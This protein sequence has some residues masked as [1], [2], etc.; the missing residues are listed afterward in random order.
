MGQKK[1]IGELFENKLNN[2]KKNPNNNLWEKIN[3]SLDAEK[4]RNKKIFYYWLVGGGLTILFGLFLLINSEGLL[5]DTP[6]QENDTPLAQEPIFSSD[7]PAE[8][9][10]NKLNERT[11]VISEEER[12]Y[13]EIKSDEKLSKN[14]VSTKGLD[15][16]VK[17]KSSKEKTLNKNEHSKNKFKKED[18]GFTVSETYYYYNSRNNQQIKT[19]NIKEIDSLISEENK[20]KDTLNVK[21]L[22]N[23]E[24]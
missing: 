13:N 18:E 14:D 1:D 19:K 6:K 5:N 7:S 22:D 21:K 8:V 10:E 24:H 16:N 12:L 4:H 17:E 23:T 15:K 2:G 3:T 20:L 9:T 11:I